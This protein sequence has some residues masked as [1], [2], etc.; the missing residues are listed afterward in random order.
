M[1]V[2]LLQGVRRCRSPLWIQPP[3]SCT[4]QLKSGATP[5]TNAC[6]LLKCIRSS[7]IGLMCKHE[8]RDLASPDAPAMFSGSCYQPNGTTVRGLLLCKGW[9]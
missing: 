6:I 7:A 2:F 1:P 9:E 5:N 3:S 8:F 4:C